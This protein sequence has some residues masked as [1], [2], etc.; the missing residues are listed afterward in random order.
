[1]ETTGALLGLTLFHAERPESTEVFSMTRYLSNLTLTLA[2]G[3]L[4]VAEFAF[5]VGTAAWLTFA[6]AIGFVAVSGFMLIAGR[7]IAQR[8]IGGVSLA[9]G[10]WT[11]VASLVFAPATVMWLGFASAVA[12]VALGITGLT[13]HELTTER[14]VHSLQV[15][16]DPVAVHEREP[17]AA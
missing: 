17:I 1:M 12:L 11:I 8:A 14:V 13:A 16:R 9:L 15:Q 3:F 6:L 2:A 4:V 5:P 10:A 7:S